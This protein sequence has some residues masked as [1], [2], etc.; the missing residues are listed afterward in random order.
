MPVMFQF[1]Y[2]ESDLDMNPEAYY[3]FGDNDMRDGR[4]GQAKVC[5][6]RQN[7]F[8]VRTKK[9][10][11]R[12]ESAYYTD[13]EY[14]ENVRKI[15]EDFR[16]IEQELQRGR[17]VVFPTEG[18]GT[19]LAQLRTRAPRRFC[20]SKRRRWSWWRSTAADYGSAYSR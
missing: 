8:G 11:G 18:M 1:R 3:V 14:H 5:R 10:P 12:S 20:T 9:A 2:Y 7:A 16:Y 6:G 13:D 19:G 4:G 17:I 15:G